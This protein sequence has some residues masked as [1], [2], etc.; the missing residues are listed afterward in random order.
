MNLGDTLGIS[1][2]NFF[3]LFIFVIVVALGLFL[4]VTRKRQMDRPVDS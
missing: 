4:Y 3:L 1:S 2:E